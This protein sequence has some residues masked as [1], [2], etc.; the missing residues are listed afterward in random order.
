MKMEELAHKKE[1]DPQGRLEKLLFYK[2]LEKFLR[3]HNNFLNK[4]ACNN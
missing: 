1:S 4:F 2:F 3:N